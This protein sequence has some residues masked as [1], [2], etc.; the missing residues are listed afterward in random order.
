MYYLIKRT[1]FKEQTGINEWMDEWIF[2]EELLQF[3]LKIKTH[4]D[5]QNKQTQ[6]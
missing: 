1:N 5:A 3:T 4:N 6:L 2:H